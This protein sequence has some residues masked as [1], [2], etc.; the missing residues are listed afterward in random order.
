M[1]VARGGAVPVVLVLGGTGFIGRHAA[2]ALLAGGCTV[3]VGSRHPQRA[4][5]RLGPGLRGCALRAVRLERSLCAGDWAGVL[6]GVDAVVNCVGILRQRGRETYDR[7]HHRAPAA[8]AEACARAGV[9]LVHVSALGLRE[10]VRSRFLHSKRAGEDAI[11]AS[12]ADWCIVRP[13]LL[14]GVGGFGARWIR[15]VARWPVH[16]LP[17]NAVGRIAAMDVAELGEALAK[18]AVAPSVAPG[19]REYELGGPTARPI[20]DQLQAMSGR[21]R[22]ALQLRL[23]AWLARLGSHAC[24]LLHL[25]PF[26]FGHYELLRFDNC[27]RPNRLPEL[28]GRLPRC[29]A[30]PP[31]GRRPAVTG[32]DTT[33]GNSRYDPAAAAARAWPR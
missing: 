7:V 4:R 32:V 12:A 15:R 2:A 13:S 18:L 5:R 9:R 33:A 6:D 19:G 28:L 25:T 27:P 17:S 21:R 24:D 22:G 3:V 26:S 1:D 20:G 10:A 16:L 30:A 14:D 11:R 8:L 23:P 31:D 29:V